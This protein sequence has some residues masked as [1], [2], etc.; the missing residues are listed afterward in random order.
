MCPPSSCQETTTSTST[1]F[2]GPREV[3]RCSLLCPRIQPNLDGNAEGKVS[4]FLLSVIA[5][6]TYFVTKLT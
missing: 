5:P 1:Q 3:Q 4:T 6:M 2:S